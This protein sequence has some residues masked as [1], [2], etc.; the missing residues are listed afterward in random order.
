MTHVGALLFTAWLAC[1]IAALICVRDMF[2]PDKLMLAA[3]GLFF[4]DIFISPYPP[5]VAAAY[6]LLLLSFLAAVVATQPAAGPAAALRGPSS[7]TASPPPSARVRTGAF[8]M[9]SIPAV[10]AQLA[11]IAHFGGIV[12]YINA[13]PMRVITF[14]G[15]GGLTTLVQTFSVI[16]LAYFAYV[17][18]LRRGG[19][20]SLA[21][22]ASHLLLFL[23]MA[24]LTGS[25]GSLLVNIVLMAMLYHHLVRR[26]SLG[27]LATLAASALLVASVLEVAREGVSFGEEGL[28]TGLSESRDARSSLGF[29]WT[30]YG[31]QTLELVFRPDDIRLHHGF[32]YLTALTN[33]V[34]R[35]WWP[36]KPD[37][38]GVV[39]TKELTGDAWGGSS[40]LSTGILPEAVIN[41]GSAA[42]LCFG[43]AQFGLLVGLLQLLYARTRSR[44]L[45]PSAETFVGG[46]RF[47]YIVWGSMGL[48]VGEFTN[49]VVTIAI[50]LLTLWVV[51]KVVIRGSP[52]ARAR[53][54]ARPEQVAAS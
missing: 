16:N 7:L 36:D 3:L 23:A 44:F 12:G 38:G 41:F 9:L 2:S 45:Q 25:R 40:H 1:G 29:A 46:V 50:Q 19:A 43:L 37:T 27:W 13:L 5:M 39:L 51:S 20:T 28:V 32:T 11:L 15:L 47:V 53:L 24:L 8:W 18:T 49:V 4:G 34:P 54:A 30:T 22:Y 31:T 42:G 33:V 52:P 17:I 26:V 10:A 21:V 14:Q 35:A 6:L 48:I